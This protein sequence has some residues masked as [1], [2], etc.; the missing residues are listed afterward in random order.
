VGR[1]DSQLVNVG[2]EDAVQE[3]DTRRL[4]WVIL[5]QLNVNLPDTALKWSIGRALESHIKLLPAHGELESVG[6]MQG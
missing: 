5:R 1:R 2:M 6:G 3:T 4:V